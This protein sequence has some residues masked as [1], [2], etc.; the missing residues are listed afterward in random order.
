MVFLAK[1][2]YRVSILVTAAAAANKIA[3]VVG[4]RAE[5]EGGRE[6]WR[7]QIASER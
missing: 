1:D 6:G 3:S 7:E 2:L 5:R 4:G